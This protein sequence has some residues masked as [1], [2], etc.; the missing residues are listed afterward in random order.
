MI[1]FRRSRP[2][3][4]QV[5]KELTLLNE[6]G[7]RARPATEFVRCVLTFESMVTIQ[8]KGKRYRADRIIEV[9]LANLNRGD[10]F[11][12][13]AEGIDATE[14]AERIAGLLVFLKEAEDRGQNSRNP[15][16]GLVD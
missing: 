5:T 2:E 8:A 10:T 7:L 9:L 4:K 16:G 12:L 1:M 15:H 3:P 6:H 11:L 14:A 13:E